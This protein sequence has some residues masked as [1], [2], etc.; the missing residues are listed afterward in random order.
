MNNSSSSHC[1]HLALPHVLLL[2][3]SFLAD[4]RVSVRTKV[5][6]EA[7]VWWSQGTSCLLALGWVKPSMQQQKLTM[8]WPD[9]FPELKLTSW[10]LGWVD[11]YTELCTAAIA[12]FLGRRCLMSKQSCAALLN[13]ASIGG[14]DDWCSYCPKPFLLSTAECPQLHLSCSGILGYQWLREKCWALPIC[15]HLTMCYKLYTLTQSLQDIARQGLYP[16]LCTH[17]PPYHFIL[18]IE[19]SVAYAGC[20]FLTVTGRLLHLGEKLERKGSARR[21]SS[22]WQRQRRRKLVCVNCTN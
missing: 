22:C 15:P 6:I 20:C 13:P 8:L 17:L 9:F 1:K 16:F 4:S 3:F 2:P 12:H 11:V 21:P 19:I 7:M 10:H 5:K 18:A 14:Q